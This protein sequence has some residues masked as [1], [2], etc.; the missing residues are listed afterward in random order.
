[1]HGKIQL[2]YE[3]IPTPILGGSALHH[4]IYHDQSLIV[5]YH[6]VK[7]QYVVLLHYLALLPVSKAPND[8]LQHG[9]LQ[10]GD[11]GAD[12]MAGGVQV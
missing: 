7:Y 6:T 8:C 10:R 12:A 9:R 2:A 11:S 3:T 4:T 5:G 1:M